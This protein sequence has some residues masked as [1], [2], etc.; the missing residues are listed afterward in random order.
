M[1]L[2]R[3]LI[4]VGLLSSDVDLEIVCRRDDDLQ[5]MSQVVE[6]IS[7]YFQEVQEPEYNLQVLLQAD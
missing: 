4:N 6:L 2:S 1:C 7:L 3:L 5:P